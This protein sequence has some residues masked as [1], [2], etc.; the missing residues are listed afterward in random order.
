[1]YSIL[2]KMMIDKCNLMLVVVRNERNSCEEWVMMAIS[3]ELMV[4]VSLKDVIMY[5]C[6]GPG[7]VEIIIA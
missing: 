3:N 5:A 4:E 1:M 7:R 6:H 2:L